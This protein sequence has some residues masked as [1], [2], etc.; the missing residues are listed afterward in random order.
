M[1]DVAAAAPPGFPA[2]IEVQQLLFENWDNSISVPHMWTCVPQT[3][4]DVVTVC[5]WAVGAKYQVRPR[6][7]MHNW[8]PLTI[9]STSRADS[10]S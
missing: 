10:G 7:I 6:G 4:A 3:E 1:T 9:A 2:G 5:N 8:S